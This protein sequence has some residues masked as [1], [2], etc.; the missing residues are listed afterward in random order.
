MPHSLQ[1]ATGETISSEELGGAQVHCSVSGCVDHF[2]GSE[3]EGLQRVREVLGSTNGPGFVA[4]RQERVDPEPGA[5][6]ED[7]ARLLPSPDD[8][9]DCGNFP[10]LDVRE[11][12]PCILCCSRRHR[13][14]VGDPTSLH[15][16][17]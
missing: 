13:P 12:P 15:L 5:S 4:R 11:K 7:F 6:L 16:C 10:M 14:H 9:T 8:V 2:G 17:R 1:A 3:E